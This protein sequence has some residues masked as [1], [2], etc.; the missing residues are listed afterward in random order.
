MAHRNPNELGHHEIPFSVGSY[1]SPS[2]PGLEYQIMWEHWRLPEALMGGTKQMR[3]EGRRYL[4]QNPRESDKA[5]T[6]RLER[7]FLANVYKRT[8]DSLA[9]QPFIKP[10]QVDNV[11]PEL[12][13]LE[14]DADSTGRSLTEIAHEMLWNQLHYGLGHIFVDHPEV[15]GEITLAEQRRLK[16]RPYFN[17]I[18]PYYLIFHDGDRVGGV[19]VINEIRFSEITV[20]RVEGSFQEDYVQRI[21][22]ITPD[23]FTTYITDHPMVQEPYEQETTAT[24]PLGKVP[25][26]TAYGNKTGFLTARPVLEDLA[27]LNL[28][29]WQSTSEQNNILHVARVPIL[30]AKG[31]EEGE[32]EG[33]EIGGDKAIV[34]SNSDAEV[35]YA[36]HS[37]AAIGSGADDLENI[38]KQMKIMG[39][40][41]LFSRSMDR[42]TA[43]ARQIDK[44]ESLSMLQTSLRGLEGT[45]EHAYK[46]AGEWIGVDAGGVSVSIGQDMGLPGNEANST[47]DLLNLNERGLISD[48]ITLAELKRRGTLAQKSD[49]EEESKEYTQERGIDTE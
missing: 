31:F 18:S 39:S 48:S 43:T 15:E 6:A 11:P 21:R 17:T 49:V 36:E 5:Y 27:W 22:S 9:A 32:L 38:E 10:V 33:M 26:A 30:V 1:D 2:T 37:G 12:Q 7:T 28:R 14:E 40:D 42:Q 13:Y 3:K 35:S 29:H 44:S 34:T 23:N 41:L 20:E 19:D 47:E 16:I 4:P 25:L 24:N 45:I 8:I 46:L